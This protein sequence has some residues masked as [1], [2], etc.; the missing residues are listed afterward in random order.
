MKKTRGR[1]H[2]LLFIIIAG[3]VSGCGPMNT[4]ERYVFVQS[5]E[6]TSP[7]STPPVKLSYDTTYLR[8]RISPRVSILSQS[9]FTANTGNH[10][11]V[12]INGGF[13]VDST[14]TPRTNQNI[15]EFKGNN[16]FWRTPQFSASLDIDANADKHLAFSFGTNY[17]QVQNQ[18]QFSWSGGFGYYLPY[19]T[20]VFRGRFE[21]GLKF[22][23][24]TYAIEYIK[25]TIL[26]SPYG[27]IVSDKVRFYRESVSISNLNYYASLV[28]NSAR[29]D[30]KYNYFFQLTFFGNSVANTEAMDF[31]PTITGLTPGIILDGGNDNQLLFG[32]QLLLIPYRSLN[33]QTLFLP[34][35]Q[36]DWNL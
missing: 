15:Y 32:V 10:T 27:N 31:S 18:K 36:Y 34:F 35:V 4:I 26:R 6:A 3:I 17:C 33:S 7:I 5:L 25:E 9:Q 19:R 2:N 13:Q 8:I 12:D 1:K 28:F 29:R 22:Q 23:K 30:W 16:L 20:D 11:L 24:S 21:A 14:S